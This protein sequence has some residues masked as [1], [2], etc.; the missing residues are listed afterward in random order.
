MPRGV[1]DLTDVQLL[2]IL[3]LMDRHGM[4]ASQVAPRFGKS[5]NAILGVRHRIVKDLAAS[6]EGATVTKPEN[7]HGGMPADWWRKRR[8]C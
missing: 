8:A 4:S 6:D 7:C 2:E 5:R 3:D 1:P